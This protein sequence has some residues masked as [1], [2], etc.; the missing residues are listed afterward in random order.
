MYIDT[1]QGLHSPGIGYSVWS[2]LR[3]RQ[4]RY[5][6]PIGRR[7]AGDTAVCWRCVTFIDWCVLSGWRSPAPPTDPPTERTRALIY[8]S[9]THPTTNCR[10]RRVNHASAQ[11]ETAAASGLRYCCE[12]VM[13]LIA[14]IQRRRIATELWPQTFRTMTSRQ[15]LRLSFDKILVEKV[16]LVVPVQCNS[17]FRACG[18]QRN[19]SK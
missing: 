10:R 15:Q 2:G 1:L 17:K 3:W 19:W 13:P 8:Y 6:R 14:L 18:L 12:S 16:L 9:Y 11:R 4:R 7:M 5:E